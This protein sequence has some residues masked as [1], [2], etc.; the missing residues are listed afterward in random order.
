[1]SC[2]PISLTGYVAWG[3]PLD[4]RPIARTSTRFSPNA[5]MSPR[6]SGEGF[7][8]RIVVIRTWL[9][10]RRE[11]WKGTTRD[12][13][14]CVQAALDF[15]IPLPSAATAKP[16]L[17]RPSPAHRYSVFIFIP[18]PRRTPV[19]ARLHFWPDDRVSRP[20]VDFSAVFVD[21]SPPLRSVCM[22]A[23]AT[24]FIFQSAD[25]LEKRATWI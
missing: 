21:P 15:N 19:S 2:P 14:W 13:G 23:N 10:W 20:V 11:I 3:T 24:S 16:A 22:Y 6:K 12:I 4:H 18:E 5:G 25:P 9:Q 1:M 7:V 8:T 17:R